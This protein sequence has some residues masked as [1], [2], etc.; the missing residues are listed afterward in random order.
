MRH[1]WV[2]AAL[3]VFP[4]AS[5]GQAPGVL[6]IAVTLPDAAQAPTPVPRHALLISDNPATR[7]PRRLV[8]AADGT[9]AI[10]L[11][12]GSYTVESDR[13]VNFLGKAY[14][15][16][17]MVDV[18][19]GRDATLALSLEN[20]DVVP[21]TAS[22]SATGT[23]APESDPS[24]LLGKWQ[25]SIVA[26]WT[27]TSRATGFVVDG[28]GLI[29]TDRNAVGLATSVEVQ[30]SP[31]VKVPARVLVSDGTRDVA[32]V[33]VD[34]GLISESPPLPL[35]CPPAAA[36]SLDEGQ[37]IVT[38]AAPHRRSKDLVWGSL[39]AFQPRA[40]ETDL[41][42]P[43]GGA[44]GPV[45]NQ[46]G[47]VVGLTSLP[48]DDDVRRAPDAMVARLGI[49]CEAM[50]AAQPKMQG[51]APP[52]PNRLP[53]EPTRPYPADALQD[54]TRG[55]T[56]PVTPPV[57]SSSDFDVSFITPPVVARAQ[58]RSGWT[59][60]SSGRSPEAEARL[61]RLTDFGA[62]SGYFADRPPVLIVRVTPKM[63]EGFWKRLAREA[64]RTQGAAL[65]P[66][67]DFK[68]SFLRMRAACGDVDVPP[69]HPFVL[70]HR[71]SEKDVIREGLYV[72]DPDGFGPRCG[73]VSL[74][75]YS[76]KA[77]EKADML[78]VDP[79]VLGQIWQDFAPYRAPDR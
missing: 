54:A 32:I 60:G 25:E 6:R 2:L 69:I 41:G 72:F 20:A 67:K 48:P 51:A 66:F 47:A 61:G 64:A 9:V 1:A 70:E 8:T 75:L 62:W 63:V 59:G 35:L 50:S 53:V 57:A 58:Q 44:G 42:L 37:E 38:I 28:R 4:G 78:T 13:P 3:L 39:T 17:Q 14:Q 16:T 76:E 21:L 79:A 73:H 12:P 24:F 65:P 46:A 33:W 71:V 68:S 34:A 18:V 55:S 23:A 74:S 43:F 22:S 36:P 7:E 52:P 56:G 27:P 77:P 45:F 31:A 49:I 5:S 10:T 40:I 29:A 30:L 11:P 15:W 19:A 26:V